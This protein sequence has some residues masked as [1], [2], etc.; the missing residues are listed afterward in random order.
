MTDKKT[1]LVVAIEEYICSQLPD[2][3]NEACVNDYAVFLTQQVSDG[4]E[5]IVERSIEETV[6]E[7]LSEGWGWFSHE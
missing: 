3:A 4:V 2:P 1:A 6:A 7:D 5:E